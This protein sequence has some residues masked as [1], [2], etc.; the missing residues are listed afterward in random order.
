PGVAWLRE[1]LSKP[2]T[3]AYDQLLRGLKDLDKDNFNF[4]PSATQVT[5]YRYAYNGVLALVSLNDFISP[6]PAFSNFNRQE[7]L[8][9]IGKYWDKRRTNLVNFLNKSKILP[10]KVEVPQ[11]FTLAQSQST[12]LSLSV[13]SAATLTFLDAVDK[14]T[15]YVIDPNINIPRGKS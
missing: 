6:K 13:V 5:A 15:T 10:V 4:T 1:T 9:A 11:P 8:Q 2:G 12:S 7:F 14:W 3:V